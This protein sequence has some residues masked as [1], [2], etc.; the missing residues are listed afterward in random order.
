MVHVSARTVLYMILR[1]AC[2]L[3]HSAR[4]D[5]AVSHILFKECWSSRFH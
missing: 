2:A 4:V 3:M 5:H 1:P